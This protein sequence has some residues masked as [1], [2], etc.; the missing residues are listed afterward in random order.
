MLTT[1]RKIKLLKGDYVELH[2]D[3]HLNSSA[4][5]KGGK[6]DGCKPAS[7]PLK[8]ALNAFMPLCVEV[9]R[10]GDDWLDEIEKEL[11]Y[12]SGVTFVSDDNGLGVVV[13]AQ[14]RR[15]YGE[16]TKAIV[17]NTPCIKS[18]EL[19][20]QESSA[21]DSL[22]KEILEYVSSLPE[23]GDLFKSKEVKEESVA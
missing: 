2:G 13:T 20:Q 19:P 23:Q 21:V 1:Y 3:A 6:L 12:V 18:T 14:L 15:D 7:Q 5:L 9:G 16:G 17:F 4:Q 22:Q 8:D 10:L 11:A